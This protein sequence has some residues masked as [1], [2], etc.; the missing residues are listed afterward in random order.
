[1]KR[2]TV[3]ALVL[4]V[5]YV[6]FAGAITLYLIDFHN[7]YGTAGGNLNKCELCHGVTTSDYNAYG[8]AVKDSLEVLLDIDAALIAVENLDSDGDGDTNIVEIMA[9]TLPGDPD[10]STPVQQSTWGAIKQ[11]YE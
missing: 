11:L 4:I 1:M 10:N 2:V 9:G 3:A 7:L 6:S 8:Q 5:L